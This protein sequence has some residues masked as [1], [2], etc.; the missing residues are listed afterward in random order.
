MF[1]RGIDIHVRMNYSPNT[2]NTVMEP[3]PHPDHQKNHTCTISDCAVLY[4]LRGEPQ[5]KPLG[6]S[7]SRKNK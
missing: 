3:T 4:I 2:T 7:S 6:K 5:S 1:V